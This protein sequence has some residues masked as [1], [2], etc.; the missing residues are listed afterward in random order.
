MSFWFW[1]GLQKGV[2]TTRYPRVYEN[3]AGVTPGRPVATQFS[4]AHEAALAAQV[5]PV[6]AITTQDNSARVNLALCIHCQRCHFGDEPV[7]EWR[8]DYEWS[9]LPDTQQRYDP[10]PKAY[11]QSL[12][13]IVVDAG[14]CGACL[15]EVKQ[16]NNPFYN[17]HRLGMFFTATPRA[18]DLLV[19]VG[20]V[21]ENMRVPLLKTYEAMPNPK[22]VLAVGTCAISGGIFGQSF[23]SAGGVSSILP[24]DL[25]I[26]GDP[27]PPLAILHG[28]LVVTGRKAPVGH[29]SASERS[30]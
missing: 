20:P 3:A 6:G 5:C 15:H 23:V 24:V 22:K 2:Q 12:H 28:L 21:S 29:E 13:I 10:L 26:P 8:S 14:D 4:S 19:V 7:M 27:A 16:L 11:K 18:A 1:R 30:S 9:R 17:V 25:E